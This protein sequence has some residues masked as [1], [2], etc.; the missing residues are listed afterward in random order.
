MRGVSVGFGLALVLSLAAV[1]DAAPH[2]FHNDGGAVN[3]Q[4]WPAGLVMAQ[5]AGKPVFLEAGREG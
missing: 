4:S 2:P 1:A 3:W 5:K